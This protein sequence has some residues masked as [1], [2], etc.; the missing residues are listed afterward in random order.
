M[1]EHQWY[2][3]LDLDGGRYTEF[4]QD[5]HHIFSCLER[6]HGMHASSDEIV[7]VHEPMEATFEDDRLFIRLGSLTWR[8]WR[9]WRTPYER[10]HPED[11]PSQWY[12]CSTRSPSAQ[13]PYDLT[14]CTS[15][16]AF[17]HHFPEITFISEA[18]AYLWSDAVH[19]Y[20]VCFPGR[21]VLPGPWS[22]EVARLRLDDIALLDSRAQRIG[23]RI[24]REKGVLFLVVEG[25]RRNILG[26]NQIFLDDGRGR[27]ELAGSI[28]YLTETQTLIEPWE[29]A[30]SQWRKIPGFPATWTTQIAERWLVPSQEYI[31]VRKIEA[32][33]GSGKHAWIPR[34]ALATFIETPDDLKRYRLQ[35]LEKDDQM[36]A[37]RVEERW[38]G[39]AEPR[40]P[41]RLPFFPVA[42]IEAMSQIPFI[43]AMMET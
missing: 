40:N 26:N 15:L 21:T 36:G 13:F 33:D 42:I 10:R 39:Y 41:Q 25:D 2:R 8:D 7:P 6:S 35:L 37:V 27:N 28:R 3:P 17:K 22:P 20:K 1:Y 9:S 16:I 14:V 11:N 19:W 32:S 4:V 29:N 23:Y 12:T 18:E 24:M 38:N 31:D 30:W 34:R 43:T 5:S